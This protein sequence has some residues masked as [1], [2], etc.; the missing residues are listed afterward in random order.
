M[1][2]FVLTAAFVAAS[3]LTVPLA[4]TADQVSVT[5]TIRPSISATRVGDSLLVRSNAPW[6]LTISCNEPG[7]QLGNVYRNDSTGGNPVIVALHGEQYSI[8]VE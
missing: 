6:V 5:V 7:C 2:M 1:R 4:A 3:L 8:C